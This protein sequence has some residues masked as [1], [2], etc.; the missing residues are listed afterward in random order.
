MSNFVQGPTEP[1]LKPRD[2]GQIL[3]Q[4]FRLFGRN[5]KSF[6]K[7]GLIS[8]IPFMVNGFVAAS[9]MP[10]GDPSNLENNLFVRV[11]TQADRGDFS[12]LI[13]LG[14]GYGVLMLLFLLLYPLV[15]GALID[16]SARAVLHMEQVPTG[17]SL[18]IGASRY[19]P[20]L[21]TMALMIPIML[22]AFPVLILGGL[23]IFSPITLPLGYAAIL[24]VTV[25][26]GQ[27]IIIEGKG[28]G[29]PAISRAYELGRSRFWPLMGLGVV[30]TLMTTV[31]SSII[32]TPLSLGA[33][34]V[35]AMGNSGAIFS[36]VY[37]L[38]GL[39]YA[40]VTPF[41]ALGQTIAY[42][43]VR[44]RKEGYD[45]EVMAQQQ[46]H[47]QQGPQPVITPP[48]PQDWQP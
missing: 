6:V 19:W 5:W 48:P 44:V 18:R 32:T 27:A 47:Q 7:I 30:F 46:Q 21:G 25:F 10:V 39:V 26:F 8:A 36:V 11:I 33:G 15:Q 16:V 1:I 14:A 13:G 4:S 17:E 43:D 28:G 20:M 9:I 22:L 45:L 29:I 34:I 2:L 35:A 3:D 24:V 37:L 42:F 12:G 40:V 38:Q 41:T 31:I 23:V